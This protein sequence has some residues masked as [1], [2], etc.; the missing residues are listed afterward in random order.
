M[1]VET[2]QVNSAGRRVGARLHQVADMANDRLQHTPLIRG[3]NV[4]CDCGER[5]LRLHGRLSS[6]YQKQVAQEVIKRIDGWND[7]VSE[8]V[9]ELV[10]EIEVIS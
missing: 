6:Y 2:E 4:A 9:A 10:N 8:G 5:V 7:L 1:H 3:T